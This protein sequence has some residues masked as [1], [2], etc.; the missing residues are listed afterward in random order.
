MKLTIVGG[1]G[2]R[3]PLVYGALLGKAERL[4]LEEVVLHDVDADRLA[5]IGAVLDGL[6]E[7][8][9]GRLPFRSTTDL[10][11]A[12]EGTDY[13]FCAIRSGRLEG[14]V[15]DEQV[16]LALGVL[17]QETTGPGGICFALRTIPE[18]VALA[19][20]MAARA[21]GAWLI[22]FTNP[23]GMVTE[24]VQEVLGRAGDRRLRLALGAVPAGRPRAR[25][26][27][28]RAR[29][30]LL[31]AQPPRLAQGRP[32]PRRRAAAR[33][34]GRR[35]R[36]RGLRGGAA[37]RRRV[38]ADARDGPERVPLLLLLRA[39]DRRRDPRERRAAGRLPARA[40]GRVLRRRRAAARGGARR[41]AGHAPRSRA[42]VHGRGAERRRGRRRARDRGERR[43]RGRGDG[44]AR[45]D[46]AEHALGADP[47]HRQPV[48]PAGA[49]R[50][51]GRRGAVG[52]RP[53]GAAAAR[54]RG[55][56]RARG[57]RWWR[58]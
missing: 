47:Q 20:A 7:E 13:V 52:G 22:N 41:L 18:M 36:A 55:G 33:A 6:A 14:R 10:D 23:A 1:G 19:E 50:P 40:A 48:Q 53:G 45:G 42:D 17:G 58:R 49:R 4:G 34:A 39:R 27:P 30:R 11:D 46:G 8:R 43:L 16:P 44:R 15:V 26:R 24:A 21:P 2:F 56:A 35:R 5:R 38:A 32:R 29:V 57:A 31:R 12:L 28:P 51:G 25:A 37:V 9:G 3:V 54:G